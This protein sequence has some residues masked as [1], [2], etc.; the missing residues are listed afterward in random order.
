[1]ENLFSPGSS[2]FTLG[3][4]SPTVVSQHSQNQP[5]LTHYVTIPLGKKFWLLDGYAL[6]D[7]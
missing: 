2:L 6:L 3:N 7:H 5:G 1:V 4:D